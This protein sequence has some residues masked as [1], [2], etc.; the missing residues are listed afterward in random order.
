MD[1]S[2]MLTM[3]ITSSA[4]AT[5]LV[6]S[7]SDESSR[8]FAQRR[9]PCQG[10]LLLKEAEDRVGARSAR[11]MA[12]SVHLL[13]MKGEIAINSI[14][15]ADKPPGFAGKAQNR[16]RFPFG[17][18]VGAHCRSSHGDKKTGEH[19]PAVR[20]GSCECT[21]SR[22]IRG[23]D[24]RIAI[25][26]R[27]RGKPLMQA[28]KLRRSTREYADRPIPPQVLSDLLWSAF[29]L[30]RPK[31]CDRTATY[32]RHAMVIDAYAETADGV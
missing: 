6:R 19:W 22:C 15:Q 18:I 1:P 21:Q 8:I 16:V 4:T 31:T 32:W 25:A 30:N 5:A 23:G 7:T 3:N 13:R 26:S 24:K 9:H 2:A 17:N 14:I 28:L 29:G 11:A 27:E 12:I 10:T 20:S